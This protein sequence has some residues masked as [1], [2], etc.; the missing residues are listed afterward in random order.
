MSEF[1]SI[2]ITSSI[3]SGL[4][5]A[6]LLVYYSVSSYSSAKKRKKQIEEFKNSLQGGMKVMFSGG[7]FGV[8]IKIDKDDAYIVVND[9]TVLNVAIYAIQAVVEDEKK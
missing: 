1:W 7:L 3:V 2:V 9:N 4:F 5:L 6:T 8:I